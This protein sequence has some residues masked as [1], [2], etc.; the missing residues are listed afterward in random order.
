MAIIRALFWDIGGV[1]LSNA[2]DHSE[3][4]LAVERFLLSKP[5][6]EGRHKELVSG[7]EEGKL[8]LDE[9]L[10]RTVFYQPRT[11]SKEE[12]KQF[13]FSLS[14]PKLQSLELARSLSGKHFMATINNESRELNQYRIQKFELAEIFD[15]FVSSCFV[16]LRKPDERIYRMALELTQHSPEECVFIDDRQ[17]NL[18]GAEKAGFRTVLMKDAQQLRR[19]LQAVG[20]EA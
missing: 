10:E 18:S 20:V 12:F 8:S 14:R 6:F 15:V 11:F 2:W 1:L 13:M 4:D 19:D 9:Y 17:E 3:R 5:E 16:G 7:F